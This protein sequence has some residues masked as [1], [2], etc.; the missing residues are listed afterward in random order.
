[1]GEFVARGKRFPL[2]RTYVMGILNV[3]PDSFSDGGR[4]LDPAAALAHAKEMEREGADVIDVGGQSTRP[5]HTPVSPEEEWSRLEAVLPAL[6][7]ETGLAV[8]VDTFYPQVAEKALKAGAHIINDV[9]GFG[10]EMLAAVAGSGCGCVVLFPQGGGGGDAAK[11]ARAFFQKR[12]EAAGRYGIGPERLCF[13]P[14]IGFGKTYEEDLRLLAQVGK[15]RLPGSAFLMAASRK[16]VTGRAAGGEAGP[17]PVEDRLAPTLAA[18]T[19]AA[20]EGADF[21]RAHDVKAAVQAA[22]MADAI[23]SQAGN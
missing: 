2:T 22:K 6:L 20:W 1:M 17:L 9:A 21:L 18:H 3:T 16:R 8:S 19:V 11:A 15:T 10:E 13:D 5:G 7:A 23:R 14:G 12:R 4:Y